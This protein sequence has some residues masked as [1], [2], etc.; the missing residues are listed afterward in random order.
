MD[1]RASAMLAGSKTIPTITAWL[2][3][4]SAFPRSDGLMWRSLSHLAA[5]AANAAHGRTDEAC[6]AAANDYD[7]TPKA[8]ALAG[9]ASE[10]Q[11]QVRPYDAHA[12]DP[13][14]SMIARA[15]RKSW[16]DEP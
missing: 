7:P 13:D 1:V 6:P 8:P 3:R 10:G 5:R 15:E 12:D 14:G 16:M 9:T 4:A 11:A 2:L